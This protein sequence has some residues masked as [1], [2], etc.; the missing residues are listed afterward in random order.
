MSG[1]EGLIRAVDIAVLENNWRDQQPVKG[2]R[3][4]I[5]HIVQVRLLLPFSSAAWWLT[6]K[7][8]GT[9]LAFGL[10]QITEAELGYL[11]LD[12]LA[13]VRHPQG[14]RVIQDRTFKP[15]KRLSWYADLAKRSGGMIHLG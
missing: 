6:E 3:S 2:T 11:D 5:D 8:P 15:E 9:S 1:W 13:S 12:E 4:E 7:E 10:C 14:P